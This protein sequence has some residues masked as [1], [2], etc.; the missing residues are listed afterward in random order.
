M[1]EHAD[2][3]KIGEVAANLMERLE[4]QIAD[5]LE[6]N[7]APPS[8]KTVAV[9]VEIDWPAD[10]E[11]DHYGSTS[12]R[13]QC[14]DPRVWIQRAFLTEAADIAHGGREPAG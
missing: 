7:E 13:Y 5:A 4:A 1:T 3:S 12:I 6:E 10:P 11:N 9:V 2:L 8:I 14:T